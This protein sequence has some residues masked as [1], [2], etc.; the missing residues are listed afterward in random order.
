VRKSGLLVS[1]LILGISLSIGGSGLVQA[2][3]GL[4]TGLGPDQW[5]TCAA[6]IPGTP[7][8][9]YAWWNPGWPA[10][11]NSAASAIAICNKWYGGVGPAIAPMANTPHTGPHQYSP[12]GLSSEK[13]AARKDIPGELRH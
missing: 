8:H 2:K 6:V 10:P 5:V 7:R 1:N 3:P 9:E 13:A 12:P 4:P 11:Y